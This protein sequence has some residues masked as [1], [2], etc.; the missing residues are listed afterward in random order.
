[1]EHCHSSEESIV[2]FGLGLP[3]A[4]QLASTSAIAQA[5]EGAERVGLSSVWVFERLIA[6]TSKVEMGGQK[7]PLPSVYNNVYSPLEVLGYVAA[8]TNRVRLGTSVMVALFH[9]P[10]DLAR[11]LAT[12]DQLSDGRIVAGLGQGWMNEE[13]EAAGVPKSRQGEGFGEFIEALRAAWKP[14][15]VSFHGRFYRFAESRLN[16]KPVQPGGPPIIVAASAPAAIKRAARM[17]LAL[18]PIWFGWEALEAIVATYRSALKEVGRDAVPI[19]LRVNEAVT[20]SPQGKEETVTGSPEQVAAAI[21]RLE[22]LGVTEVFW[23]MPIPVD[24]QL[25]RLGRL[26][27]I[28]G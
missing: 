21:P 26:I 10:A 11:R 9:N 25:E 27:E 15:P 18:N 28:T 3:T 2:K 16:P 1:M 5:A 17:G 24:E 13:F 12:L 22:R 23:S 20:D 6:P 8:R 7:I 4:G 19:Y 14:D